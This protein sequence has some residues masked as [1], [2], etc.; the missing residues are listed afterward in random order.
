MA[1]EDGIDRSTMF[2][3]VDEKVGSVEVLD[4]VEDTFDLEGAYDVAGNADDEEAADPLIEEKLWGDAGVGAADDNRYRLLSFH[5]LLAVSMVILVF[6]I[7]FDKAFI[8][9][10]KRLFGIA[11]ADGKA[12]S[13]SE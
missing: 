2:V 5:C 8:A 7:I 13:C 4:S 10:D 12:A 3:A 1:D 6:E 11:R 9:I